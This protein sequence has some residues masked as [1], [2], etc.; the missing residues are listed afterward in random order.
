MQAHM[1]AQRR[2]QIV[3]PSVSTLASAL[4]RTCAEHKITWLA[5]VF[6]INAMRLVLTASILQPTAKHAFRN[7]SCKQ[8]FVNNVSLACI[9]TIPWMLNNVWLRRVVSTRAEWST[10]TITHVFPIR[11]ATNCI[12]ESARILLQF[13]L[14]ICR[15][16]RTA[17]G[18]YLYLCKQLKTQEL[19]ISTSRGPLML[20]NSY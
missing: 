6:A 2:F 12:V 9:T 3:D 14:S 16:A 19:S 5:P 1:L 4:A 20:Q 7:N 15:T 11:N 13:A 17:R 10:R 18:R 8:V